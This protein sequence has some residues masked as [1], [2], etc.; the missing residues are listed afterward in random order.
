MTLSPHHC[1]GGKLAMKGKRIKFAL[2]AFAA[3][4]AFI[5]MP[6]AAAADGG[7]SPREASAEAMIADMII[8][9]PLGLCAT[10][11]GLGVFIVSL[12]FTSAAGNSEDAAKKLVTDPA[13]Y[14]FNRPLGHPGH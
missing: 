10:V 13:S 4:T 5:L 12:P 2:L 14:T 9:R 8:L 6:L 3:A 1:S 7:K 11:I